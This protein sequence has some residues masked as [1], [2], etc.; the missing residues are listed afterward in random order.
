ML[1]CLLDYFFYTK[2]IIWCGIYTNILCYNNYNDKDSL[3]I[4]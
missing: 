4:L 2:I 3:C 1:I